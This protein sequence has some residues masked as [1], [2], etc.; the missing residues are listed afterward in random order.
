MPSLISSNW[1]GVSLLV[2]IFVV[3]QLLYFYF[4]GWG[5]LKTQWKETI[6]IDVLALLV[7]WA[8]LYGWSITKIV[9][10]DHMHFVTSNSQLNTA[11][12]NLEAENKQLKSQP[13][14]VITRTLPPECYFTHVSWSTAVHPETMVIIHCNHKINAPYLIKATLDSDFVDP[15]FLLPDAPAG[16]SGAAKKDG[17][18]YTQEIEVPALQANQAALVMVYGAT[19]R[20]PSV[21]RADIT[22]LK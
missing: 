14:K 21:L 7:G 10:D 19:T 5:K 4:R 22:P 8:G 3:A 16:I 15:Q 13:E 12:E 2:A 20:N 18:T 17:Y 6:F 11:I 9:Y 1:L